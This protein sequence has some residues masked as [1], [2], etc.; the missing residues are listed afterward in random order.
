MLRLLRGAFSVYR[1]MSLVVLFALTPFVAGAAPSA[2][3]VMDA[4]SGEVLYADNA[5]SRLHPASLTKMMTLYI[6]FEAVRLGEISLDTMV[7]ISSNAAAEPPSK[8]G[9]RAGQRIQ[10]RYLIRAA[11]VKSANDAATAIGEAIEG[12]EAAFARRMNRTALALGMTRTTFKNANGLTE[13]GHLSTAR[14]MAIL[15]RHVFYDYPQYYNIFSRRTTNAGG[16]QVSNTNRRFLDAYEGADGIK[17]GYTR[18]AGFNLVASA[19]RRRERIIAS[20]FG[21]ASTAARNAKMA[22]LLDLGF[23]RA[24]SRVPVNPPSLPRYDNLPAEP[25]DNAVVMASADGRNPARAGRIVRSNGAPS[26]SLIPRPRSVSAPVEE[27][28]AA[29]LAAIQSNVDDA[30]ANV[31]TSED[32]P[33]NTAPEDASVA[34]AAAAAAAEV[35][36]AT[37]SETGVNAEETPAEAIETATDE[38]VAQEEPVQLA[39]ATSIRPRPRPVRLADNQTPIAGGTETPPAALAAEAGPEAAT[40]AEVEEVN[41]LVADSTSALAAG[42]DNPPTAV[43]AALS[44]EPPVA[45]E[46]AP[47][48]EITPV[49]DAPTGNEVATL[50]P[51]TRPAPT[52]AGRALDPLPNADELML[53]TAS[54]MP[55]PVPQPTIRPEPESTQIVTRM[56]TSG[57]HHSG[58]SLG[59]FGTRDQAERILITVALSEMASF[60]GALRRVVRRPTGFEANFMGLTADEAEQACHRI[61]SR[62]RDCSIIGG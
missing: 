26:R 18:A 4:R 41:S 54:V 17:T 21:G 31:S 39:A 32:A 51:E 45:T 25:A 33:A 50:S 11:A 37:A 5:D 44:D 60:N 1:I 8:L 42:V 24:R 9:L 40:G 57:G 12:S 20:V 59:K 3:L 55:A 19:Q 43:A 56:S 22:E 14:D 29:L 47:Q 10:L 49:P 58:I 7:T 46:N 23:S 34:E 13:R 28:S 52:P 48:A 16:T 61:I 27:P 53:E 30:I 35:V 2:A 6:A 38:A 15:G 62:G 36:L